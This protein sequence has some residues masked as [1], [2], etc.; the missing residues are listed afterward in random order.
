LAEDP[1]Q[2]LP[3]AAD[4]LLAA[5]PDAVVV[6][7]AGGTVV[8]ATPAVEE[9][10]GYA[11]AELVGQP[12]EV[13]VPLELR[14]SHVADRTAYAGHPHTRPMGAGLGLMGRRRDGGQV[15]V[16]VALAPLPSAGAPLFAAFIRDATEQR[17]AEG[18]LAA[19]NEIS[20]ALL[21]GSSAATLWTLAARHAR[22]LGSAA[23]AVAVLPQGGARVPVITAGDG[24]GVDALVGRDL[25]PEPTFAAAVLRGE[26][27]LAVTDDA[28][29]GLGGGPALA[30]AVADRDRHFGTLLVSRLPES[31]QFG[32]TDIAVLEAFAASA[33]VAI[34][35][36][37]A[38]ADLERLSMVEEHD[39]I[40]RDLHDT[41]IQRLFATGMSL[42]AV[43]RLTAEPISA[44]I[45]Q[46]VE[47]LD[48][49]IRQIRSTIFELQQPP[50]GGGSVRREV[51]QVVADA[52]P[53][54]TAPPRVAFAGP[55][56]TMVPPEVTTHLLAVVREALANAAR[57][58][59]ARAV[60]VVVSLVGSDLVL[61]VTDDGVGPPE[62]P[63][64]GNGLRNMASRA[65]QLGGRFTL[66]AR[67]P[68]GTVLEWRVPIL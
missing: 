35:L 67:R 12:V 17:R 47:E 28:D 9:L 7:D 15:P 43:Q 40:A 31:P 34:A 39:R 23:W 25:A 65:E 59:Q 27:P 54:M 19:I 49:T 2:P 44:R 4:L 61:V 52:A 30:I 21:A 45:G 16:D 24:L 38:R 63:T 6:I 68:K 22:T 36:G 33:A 50:G 46:A 41:V 51:Q 3:D 42:S 8:L 53:M 32:P 13:L 5:S 66:S 37:E 20:Q 55:I 56:D 14:A 10:F 58:A 62:G 64:A 60:E 48:D 26:E 1:C 57:H 29:L 18:R 11:P